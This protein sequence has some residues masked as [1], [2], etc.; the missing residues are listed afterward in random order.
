MRKDFAKSLKRT[1]VGWLRNHSK[2]VFLL[3]HFWRHAATCAVWG[4]SE[5]VLGRHLP[6]DLLTE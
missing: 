4:S 5:L 2:L 6:E 1:H 3:I